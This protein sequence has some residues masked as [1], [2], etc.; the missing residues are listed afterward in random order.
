MARK[1]QKPT[2]EAVEAQTQEF[3]A[4]ADREAVF[5]ILEHVQALREGMESLKLPSNDKDYLAKLQ[6][7][8][9][10]RNAI[11]LKLEV[12]DVVKDGNRTYLGV[13]SFQHHEALEL[14]RQLAAHFEMTI[15]SWEQQA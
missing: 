15:K 4:N 9:A 3:L 8:D 6:A 7:A 12:V 1:K 11:S 10:A 2:P 13:G 5:A 14:A